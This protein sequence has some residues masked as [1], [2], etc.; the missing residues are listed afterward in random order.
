LAT[1]G[2]RQAP[3][4]KDS[5]ALDSNRASLSQACVWSKYDV[6]EISKS[7]ASHPKRIPRICALPHSK[8]AVELEQIGLTVFRIPQ[9]GGHFAYPK[10]LLIQAKTNCMWIERREYLVL[11]DVATGSE[12]S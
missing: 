6:F 3:H 4:K 5:V 1:N 12:G 7:W 9:I 8:S 10:H 2:R 11:A